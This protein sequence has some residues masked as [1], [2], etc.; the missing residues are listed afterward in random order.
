MRDFPL[1]TRRQQ[2][3]N[4]LATFYDKEHDPVTDDDIAKQRQVVA[5]RAG[6][7]EVHGGAERNLVRWQGSCDAEGET[8]LI[9][10]VERIVEASVALQETHMP[11]ECPVCGEEHMLQ[12]Q[13]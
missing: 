5:D 2:A 6:L 4:T 13:T 11:I 12:R 1:L 9:I 10:S 7:S 3:L 8:H